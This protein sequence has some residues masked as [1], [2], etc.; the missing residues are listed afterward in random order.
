MSHCRVAIRRTPLSQAKSP[1]QTLS[2]EIAWHDATRFAGSLIWRGNSS[3]NIV[4]Q[5]IRDAL[6]PKARIVSKIGLAFGYTVRISLKSISL[7][8]R[9]HKSLPAPAGEAAAHP[10]FATAVWR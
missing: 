5:Q 2:S 9:R 10:P 1:R 6:S 4:S 7:L 3:F 8:R